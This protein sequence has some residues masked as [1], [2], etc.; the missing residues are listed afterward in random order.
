[1]DFSP[2]LILYIL[3]GLL[4]GFFGGLLGIGGGLIAVPSLLFTFYLVNLP[5]THVMQLAI[6]T[7]LGA[8]VFTAA[9]SAWAHYRQKGVVWDFFWKLAPGI[10]IGTILGSLIV[11]YLPSKELKLI[12]GLLISIIGI[13]FLLPPE[14]LMTKNSRIRPNTCNMSLSGVLIGA[15]SSLL[16]IGGG[17]MTVPV[18]TFF[19]VPLKNAISTSAVTGFLIAIVGA[20]S[21]LYLGLDKEIISG[22]LGYLYL[23]A[24]IPIGIA[25]ALTAPFGAKLAY[26]LP[27]IVLSRIFG[28]FF[29]I[30][31]MTMIAIAF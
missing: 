9:S 27:Q 8:M 29:G 12:F 24:F 10:L 16:G 15:T 5:E 11:D 26:R 14:T 4:A 28:I 3:T 25:A 22:S 6:G 21:F 1:M 7:S 20:I 18:L 13:S 19:Q 30:V 2:V 31:G 23:P 17:I